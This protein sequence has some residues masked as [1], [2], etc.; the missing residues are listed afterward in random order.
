MNKKFSY[1]LKIPTI[2]LGS[3]L[4]LSSIVYFIQITKIG[5]TAYYYYKIMSVAMI[6]ILPLAIV[7]YSFGLE[8]LT[9]KINYT[10]KT[11]IL[12]SIIFIMLIIPQLTDTQSFRYWIGDR[13]VSS[14]L[15]ESIYQHIRRISNTKHYFDGN[16]TFYYLANEPLQSA[17]GTMM[18]KASKPDSSC[19]N[20]VNYSVNIRMSL[21]FDTQSIGAACTNGY[22]VTIITDPTYSIILQGEV[23]S[24]NLDKTVRIIANVGL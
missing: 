9:K 5:Q 4:L 7:G 23:K 2:L 16:Y 1:K 14:A 6:I 17:I 24:A 11:I 12:I 22:H 13:V 15:N 8:W 21:P 20:V 10:S 3:I 19:F 18:L